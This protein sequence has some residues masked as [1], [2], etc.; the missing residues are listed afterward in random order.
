LD[1][2]VDPYCAAV[3]RDKNDP[4]P[5]EVSQAHASTVANDPPASLK[6]PKMSFK[7]NELVSKLQNYILSIDDEVAMK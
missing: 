6:M 3:A 7:K 2:D 1:E 4:P 5:T